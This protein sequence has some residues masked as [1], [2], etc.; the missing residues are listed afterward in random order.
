MDRTKGYEPFNVGSSPTASALY[1]RLAQL[2]EHQILI[3]VVMSSSLIPPAS[4]RVKRKV[5]PHWDNDIILG[6]HDTRDSWFDS[7]LLLL[8]AAVVKW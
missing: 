2:V 1:R 5:V 6:G 7:R 3:L 8:D 4:K